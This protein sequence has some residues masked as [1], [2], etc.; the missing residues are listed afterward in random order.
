MAKGCEAIDMS[1]ELNTGAKILAVGLEKWQ[2]PPGVVRNTVKAVIKVGNRHID[3][4]RI[5]GNEKEVGL[6][7]KEMFQTNVVK[8][9]D[10]WVTSKLWCVDHALE[11]VLG[12]LDTTLQD[13]QLVTL[14]IGPCD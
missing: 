2:A 6:A 5:Y 8:S 9:E 14:Y 10:L 4:A 13:L 11:D 7:L 3:C 1:F 12:A